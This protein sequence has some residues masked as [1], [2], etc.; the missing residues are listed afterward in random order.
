MCAA[1]A[2]TGFGRCCAT[3][4]GIESSTEGM[5]IIDRITVID[6]IMGS[7]KTTA[8]IDL[9]KKDKRNNYI[10]VTPYLNEIERVIKS[11]DGS[12]KQPLNFG[13]GKLESLHRQ[14]AMGDNIV[15][16]HALFLRTTVETVQLIREGG[17]H[18]I[19][20]EALDIFK[21]YNSIVSELDCKVVKK[22]D[23]LW[24]LEDKAIAISPDDWSVQWTGP[25]P[26]DC[27]Y[28]EVARLSAANTLKCVDN[29]L[30][31]EFP[32]DIFKAFERVYILTYMF[33]GSTFASYLDMHNLSYEKAAIQTTA[34]GGY[35]LSEY[36]DDIGQRSKYAD[37]INIYDG[38]L[39]DL[40][41]K[42]HAFSINNLRETPADRLK[43]IQNAMRSYRDH[44]HASSAQIMWTTSKQNDFYRKLEGKGFKYTRRLTAEER[45]SEP[46]ELRC[47]VPCNARA[48]N[49]FSERTV[50]LY[51]LNRFPHPEVEKYFAHMG[52]SLNKDA[53]ATS[54]LLQWIWRSAIRNGQ[55]ID[56]YI[57]SSRMR[58]LLKD[59][60]GIN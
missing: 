8:M 47:F 14:L 49:D 32:S 29:A 56:L 33:E 41:E 42:R 55:R 23:I 10:Y 58:R 53:F 28:S 25:A 57:P 31:W 18:L 43:Q 54:E 52:A 50:L 26:G 48:T 1:I 59:W 6:S 16:T 37:L 19:L 24:L 51:L 5:K 2:L 22:A 13:E 3:N 35:Q 7:G 39:N 44:V 4:N 40:G 21:D 36:T 60:L 20:D 27:H 12:F 17:Y 34:G 30:C 9:V 46:K 11:T 15:T 38:P 45:K